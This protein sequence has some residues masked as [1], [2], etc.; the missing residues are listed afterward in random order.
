[1]ERRLA[2]LAAVDPDAP[3]AKEAQR[4]VAEALLPAWAAVKARLT[5]D[6]RAAGLEMGRILRPDEC[7]LSPSDFG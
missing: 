6:A 3:H 7:C 1:V 4:F 5:G 2:R